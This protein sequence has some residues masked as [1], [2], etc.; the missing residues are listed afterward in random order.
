[1]D[2]KKIILI[3]IAALLV[4]GGVSAGVYRWYLAYQARVSAEDAMPRAL[5]QDPASIFC[6]TLKGTA[7]MG[8]ENGA[9]V[10]TC[11]LPDGKT[12]K[13]PENTTTPYFCDDK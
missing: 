3:G 11:K 7:T 6:G 8:T 5:P 10:V 2:M 13:L 1:M 4:L 9:V 12:C